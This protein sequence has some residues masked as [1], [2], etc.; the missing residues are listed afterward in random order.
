MQ[1]G[2]NWYLVGLSIALAMVAAY[3]ALD[4]AG[5]V[6]N[7]SGRASWLWLCCGAVVMGLGIWSMHFVG[8]LAFSPPIRLAYDP[9]LTF[10]SLL[11]AILTS[12]FA[13]AVVS[14][15]RMTRLMLAGGAVVMAAGIGLMHRLGMDALLE[16]DVAYNLPLYAGSLA[17]AVAASLATL[18]LSF[19]LRE[20]SSLEAIPVKLGA[21]ALIG[22]AISGIHYMDM[23]AARFTPAELGA[24]PHSDI[25]S[26]SLGLS[27]GVA[28]LCVLGAAILTSVFDAHIEKRA[29][30]ERRRLDAADREL[31]R[32]IEERE[33]HEDNFRAVFEQAG[34]GIIL[35]A[36]NGLCLEANQSFLGLTG[37]AYGELVG[38]GIAQAVAEAQR[39]NLPAE[40][41]NVV[42]GRPYRTEWLLLKRDGSVFPTEISATLL[43][44]GRLLVVLREITERKKLELALQESEEKHR[45]VLET[46]GD[47]VALVDEGQQ[48]FYVNAAI[49]R[50]FGYGHGALNG[51]PVTTLEPE[52]R[53]R[54]HAEL[55]RRRLVAGGGSRSAAVTLQ[56]LRRD[57]SE[58]PVEVSLSEVTI[59]G[60]RM[61]A[62]FIRDVTDKKAAE[63]RVA[64]LQRI[65][66][67]LSSVNTLIVHSR[68]RQDLLNGI[69]RIAAEQGQ[70]RFAWVAGAEGRR[71]RAL[72]WAGNDGDYVSRL[73]LSIDEEAPGGRGPTAQAL[74]S[75]APVTTRDVAT[76]PAL[77]PWR[78]ELV[79]RGIR[80]CLSLPFTVGDNQV[81]C[82][83]LYSSIQGFFTADEVGLL[84]ELADDVAYGLEFI[85]REERLEY[86]AY[87]DP[88]T[89]LPNRFMLLERLAAS[90]QRARMEQR[91][92]AVMKLDLQNFRA[93]N[94]SVGWKGGNEVLA[95]VAG[96]LL[97]FAD[98]VGH[99]ARSAG[100]RF[101][102]VLDKQPPAEDLAAQVE[103]KLVP[104]LARPIVV[105]GKAF[106]VSGRVGVA[107]FPEDGDDADMLTLNAETAL[108]QA[109]AN[110]E[111]L[112]FYSRKMG[113]TLAERLILENRLSAAVRNKELT[114]YYQPKID[115][116]SGA[117]VGAEALIRWI[118]P[119][120][121]LVPPLKF[122]SLLE[123]SGK[124][125]DVG[126]WALQQAL[127]DHRTWTEAGRPAVPLAVNVS[128][129]QLRQDDFVDM[130]RSLLGGRQAASALHIEITESTLMGNIDEHAAKLDAVRDMGVSI[131]I[132]DFGTGYSSLSYLSRLPIDAVKIDRSFI[133]RM[134]ENA[135]TMGVISTIL[136]LAHSMKLK[137][138]A[139]GV[140]SEEQ[141]R[142]LRLLR[143][144]EGQGWLFSKALP[145]EAFAE[146][147]VQ[148]PNLQGRAAPELVA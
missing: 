82:L 96:R 38:Q 93:I 45:A 16:P 40:I 87:Y 98:G 89:R 52:R 62:V 97:D 42:A 65:H 127:H 18:Y 64:R 68:K 23:V 47:G 84:K 118:S 41:A 110:G 109:K 108:K 43:R 143:C 19:H 105:S 129:V 139:E 116:R 112:L 55:F 21:A 141:L 71:I 29:E 81:F 134:S 49:E 94:D 13:L 72:A 51:Q 99:V 17:V 48:L 4:I 15:A 33:R 88:V 61:F 103:Q 34:D 101:A 114:L 76:D 123:E 36:Q 12:G 142:F 73:D 9:A 3:S 124:I 37:Y 60:R 126:H 14:R 5:R 125:I 122:V 117:I 138:I 137:A 30:N 77:Q 75:R 104:L 120:L 100:D 136:S 35:L 26:L 146:L 46:T 53:R 22:L 59:A 121:G 58:F 132:D 113:T 56:G 69:C 66:A 74:R 144:D 107:R 111:R 54:R 6:R 70:F 44:D 78:E 28:V 2:Y 20:R 10:A 63:E 133:L 79:R 25:T 80:S 140:E 119:E 67:V 92:F 7:S 91:G 102:L 106:H 11:L 8:I 24:A 131:A 57:G 39:E 27:I 128:A 148:W 85:E 115:L 145:A 50:M 83:N 90:I 86:L 147:L 32:E 31:R 1:E 95:E 130:F 135:D